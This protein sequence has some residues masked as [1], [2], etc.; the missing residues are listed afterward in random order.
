MHR[1]TERPAH[2]SAYPPIL[3]I[4]ADMRAQRPTLQVDLMITGSTPATAAMLQQT[5]T[6]P[7]IFVLVA[8]PLGRMT[9]SSTPLAI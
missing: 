3:S 4:I 6:I 1:R 5:R 2:W 7:I 8:D 9:L